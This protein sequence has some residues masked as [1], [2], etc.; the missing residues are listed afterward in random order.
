MN[1]EQQIARDLLTIK[2]V[3]LSTNEPFQWVSGIKAPIYTDNRLTIGYPDVRMHISCGLAR[4]IVEK[5]PN[6]SA[7]GGVV[8]AGIPHA[9]SVADRLGLPLCYIRSE[10]KDHG[11]GKQIEGHLAKD[12]KIVLIDDLISTGGSVLKAAQALKQ[13]GYEV[14]GVA[15][16]FSYELPSGNKNF[17][18]AGL[19]LATLTNY[20]T[21]IEEA[22]KEKILT[23]EEKKE[24]LTWREDPWSWG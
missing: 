20:S 13:A 7:I 12:A 22:Q 2:A 6:V 4:L 18:E 19:P 10:P 17:T 15:A 9:T 21:L 1:I 23:P 3:T 11:K 24:L 5:F 8:T 14:L 16:I